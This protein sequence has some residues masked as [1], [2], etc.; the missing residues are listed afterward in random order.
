[1][2]SIAQYLPS[3]RFHDLAL[4]RSK[5]PERVELVPG[6]NF[7][8]PRRREQSHPVPGIEPRLLGHAGRMVVTTM[9]ELSRR[10]LPICGNDAYL[11]QCEDS[12]ASEARCI[13]RSCSCR[14]G[15]PTGC[16][17]QSIRYICEHVT[18]WPLG[19]SKLF[20]RVMIRSWDSAFVTKDV[21]VLFIKP[22]TAVCTVMKRRLAYWH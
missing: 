4:S 6:K 1:M 7:L 17:Q 5:S 19:C 22:R 11:V 15:P 13:A 18:V 14:A 20:V 21:R 10:I 2:E 16:P 3:V 8:T 9:T 12:A